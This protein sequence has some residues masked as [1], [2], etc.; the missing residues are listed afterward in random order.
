MNTIAMYLKY[1]SIAKLIFFSGNLSFNSDNKLMKGKASNNNLNRVLISTQALTDN[2]LREVQVVQN[3]KNI[4]ITSCVKLTIFIN[5]ES[6]L[7]R[8]SY[9]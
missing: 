7:K 9:I 8:K 6:D 1:Q 5:S 2:L 4:Q 3:S